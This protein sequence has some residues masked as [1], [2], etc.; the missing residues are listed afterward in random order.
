MIE[1]LTLDQFR[2]IK[3]K[4]NGYVAITDKNLKKNCVHHTSCYDVKEQYFKQK[5]IS[6]SGKNGSY[7]YVDDYNEALNR[8]DKM[9]KCQKCF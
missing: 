8:F 1:L 3:E 4:R 5:V 6:S 7:Y 2:E 9:C